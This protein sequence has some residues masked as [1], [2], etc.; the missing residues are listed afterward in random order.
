MYYNIIKCLYIPSNIM[1][2]AGNL[3]IVLTELEIAKLEIKQ[4]IIWFVKSGLYVLINTYIDM[5]YMLMFFLWYIVL[6]LWKTIIK[7]PN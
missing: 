1:W 2:S 4:E 3:V 7:Y 6:C 5:K